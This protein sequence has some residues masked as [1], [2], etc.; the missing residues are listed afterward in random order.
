MPPAFHGTVLSAVAITGSHPVG[1]APARWNGRSERRHGQQHCHFSACDDLTRHSK[2]TGGV[3][4]YQ[5]TDAATQ[6]VLATT[7]RLDGLTNTVEQLSLLAARVVAT[8]NSARPVARGEFEATHLER[9]GS[10]SVATKHRGEI[11]ALERQVSST[12]P[13]WMNH[14]KYHTLM[15][16]G[17]QSTGGF[18]GVRQSGRVADGEEAAGAGGA[19]CRGGCR[20]VGLSCF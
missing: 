7:T 6:R 13:V 1:G 9:S 8:G 10:H 12:D 5:A 2:Q 18:T 4:D 11:A 15:P 3:V 20:A 19:A 14:F 16:P 17:L